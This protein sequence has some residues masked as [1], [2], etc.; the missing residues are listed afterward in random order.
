VSLNGKNVDGKKKLSGKDVFTIIDRSFRFELP[1]MSP[2]K[3]PVKSPKVN[4]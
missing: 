3:T 1:E 4:L 2:K